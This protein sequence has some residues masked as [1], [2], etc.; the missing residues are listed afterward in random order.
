MIVELD[1]MVCKIRSEATARKSAQRA[2]D[3]AYCKPLADNKVPRV[4]QRYLLRLRAFGDSSAE[5]GPAPEPF[6]VAAYPHDGASKE[7]RLKLWASTPMHQSSAGGLPVPFGD[8]A[9]SLWAGLTRATI[10]VIGT[11]AAP[12]GNFMGTFMPVPLMNDCTV[13][14]G[15]WL[16]AELSDMPYSP[17]GVLEWAVPVVVAARVGAVRWTPAEL[18]FVGIARVVLVTDG[19]FFA[20]LV[21]PSVFIGMSVSAMKA[22]ECLLSIQA[23]EF[24]RRSL[25]WPSCR[26]PAGSSLWVPPGWTLGLVATKPGGSHPAS[27]PATLV[28]QPFASLGLHRMLPVITHAWV[29][30]ALVSWAKLPSTG[31]WPALIQ[32]AL[33]WYA[34]TRP[35]RRVPAASV[36]GLPVLQDGARGGSDAPG[37]V[38]PSVEP[39][40]VLTIADDQCPAASAPAAAA[41]GA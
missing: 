10:S 1:E 27:V 32:T 31:S 7:E 39:A 16:P 24:T 35:L 29:Q 40:V 13:E 23:V 25:S 21:P 17:T 6:P 33:R 28:L 4:W 2:A 41:P 8:L 19:E 26:L 15:Q 9:S 12:G 3:T 38:S 18:P 36:P 20:W 11:A 5:M 14:D 37:S 22:P 34:T 30:L